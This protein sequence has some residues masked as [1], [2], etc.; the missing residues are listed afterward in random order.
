VGHSLLVL[1]VKGLRPNIASSCFDGPV[2]VL[3]V[4]ECAVLVLLSRA[5]HYHTRVRIADDLT[6]GHPVEVLGGVPRVTRLYIDHLVRANYCL[7][8]SCLPLLRL[9]L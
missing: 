8:N 9:V 3:I 2:L 7:L 6:R 4:G 1:I 5:P